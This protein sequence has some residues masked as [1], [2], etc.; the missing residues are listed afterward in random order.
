M[1]TAEL[2]LQQKAIAAMVEWMKAHQLPKN[3]HEKGT[4]E[5]KQWDN[6]FLGLLCGNDQY[7]IE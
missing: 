6:A 3:P 1:H 2:E 7:D 4:A 5:Y